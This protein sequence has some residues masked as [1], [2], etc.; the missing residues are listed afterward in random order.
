MSG[1]VIDMTEELRKHIEMKNCNLCPLRDNRMNVVQGIGNVLSPVMIVGEAPGEDEDV[2]GMPFVGRSGKVLA[3]GLNNINITRREVY[4]T[5]ACKCRPKG[6]RNPELSELKAC[7]PWL[8]REIEQIKPKLI[9]TLGAVA[10]GVFIKC[11]SVGAMRGRIINLKVN[12]Q[13]VSLLVTYHPS[14]ILR[15]RAQLPVFERDIS[16]ILS[17]ME[18]KNNENQDD[19]DFT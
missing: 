7:A 18:D 11:P 14:Y 1:K 9:V 12:E 13:P 5:N 2:L 15:N 3:K 8:R 19:Q 4:V 6:N 10:T 16:L 17:F